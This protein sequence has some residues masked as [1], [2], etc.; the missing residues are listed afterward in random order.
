MLRTRLFSFVFWASV[1]N[2]GKLFNLNNRKV[3]R[4]I[5]CRVEIQLNAEVSYQNSIPILEHYFM[6]LLL[7]REFRLHLVGG[8]LAGIR[9]NE[10]MNKFLRSL[11]KLVLVPVAC[12]F[13]LVSVFISQNNFSLETWIVIGS[14]IKIHSLQFDHSE[15]P[16][17]WMRI[18]TSKK[19]QQKKHMGI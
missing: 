9:K 3:A 4:D 2:S 13:Y 6:A 12:N 16:I 8:Q 19:K 11:T 15:G 5:L 1:W 10:S 14:G 7:G 17:L 18:C